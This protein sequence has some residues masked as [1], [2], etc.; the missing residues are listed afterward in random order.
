RP[1]APRK[2]E[3]D[4]VVGGRDGEQAIR[5]VV[6]HLLL[7]HRELRHELRQAL[8]VADDGP[9]LTETTS[10]PWEERPAPRVSVVLTVYNYAGVVRRA[11]AG[12]A[13]STLRDVEVVIVDH[14]SSAGSPEAIR[15]ALQEYPWLP[16]KVIVRRH[17]AG[18]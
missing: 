17:N 7:E 5:M 9:E 10:G 1:P 2:L 16:A 12:V 3:I 13:M 14:A 4:N 11:L 6:K 8:E 15:E 18:L